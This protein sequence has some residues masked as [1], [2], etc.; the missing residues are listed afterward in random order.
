MSRLRRWGAVGAALAGLAFS[1]VPVAGAQAPSATGAGRSAVDDLGACLA[2]EREGDLLVLIDE[3]SSLQTSDPDGARVRAATYLLEQLA[4]Y[5]VRAGVNL[6]V[7][8]SG[9]AQDY[10]PQVPFTALTESSLPEIR[11]AVDEFQGRTAGGDTDYWAALDGA[12]KTLA[13]RGPGRCQA[14]AWFTDG[15]LDYSTDSGREKPYAPG[16][17]IGSQGDVDRVIASARESICR[18]GGVADQMRSSGVVTLGVGLASGTASESDFGLMKSI[19]TGDPGPDGACGAVQDP[20]PGEFFL[21]QNINDLLFAFDAM[22]TPGQAPIHQEAGVCASAL[23]ED[24][25]HRFVLD[26]SI[27][28]VSILARSDAGGRDV[29]LVLPSGEQVVIKAGS[30]AAPQTADS[31]VGPI[32][33]TWHS[34]ET[35]AIEMSNSAAAPAWTGAWALAF[36]DP[37][38]DARVGRSES[39]IHIAGNLFPAWVGQK[40]DIVHSGEVT[41]DVTLGVVDAERVPVEPNKLLGDVRLSASVIGPD[42]RE[43]VVADGMTKEQLGTPVDLDLTSV[44]PG[45]STM[46]MTLAVT[47]ASA[48]GPGGEQVPGTAL[49]PSVVDMPLNIAAPVGFPVVGQSLDFGTVEGAGTFTAGLP[50]TGPGCVWLPTKSAPGLK[51]LGSPDGVGAVSAGSEQ[52]GTQDS[53]LVLAEGESAELPVTLTTQNEA[54]GTVNGVV[55]VSIAPAGEFDRAIAVDVPFTANV[56]KPLD[57]ANFWLT[58]VMA[59][60]LGPGIPLLL[61]YAAK[62]WTAKIPGRALS[63]ERIAITVSG[64]SVLRDDA[65]FALRDTDLINPVPGL[66]DPVRRLPVAGTELRTHVG[67]SPFGAGFVTAEAAGMIGAS[68]RTPST[69]GK[70]LAARLPLAV[71][72]NWVVLHDPTGPEDRAEVLLLVG[73]DAGQQRRADMVDDINRRLPA[74]LVELR[75]RWV[76]ANPGSGSGGGEPTPQPDPFGG[77]GSGQSFG[78]GVN[79]PGSPGASENPFGSSTGSG[80]DPYAGGTPSGPAPGT[81]PPPSAPD[82]FRF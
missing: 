14:V 7:A 3:S 28:A 74:L 69:H 26:G 34:P 43:T 38:G 40:H 62:W 72:N 68:S 37:T 11:T 8:V 5:G 55:T 22:S 77:V 30:G 16:V 4:G 12:R 60:V 47:T 19:V 54:N 71:H 76:Q 42:G 13:D 2:A 25:K 79:F 17:T 67:A 58:L 64:S 1:T 41:K 52:S 70:Q 75:S 45:Q 6:D 56:Q 18:P 39:N 15:K 61:L 35:V 24:A 66:G 44:P 78:A 9:F 81:P 82:P 51:V 57:A 36:V 65:Q 46:R 29:Y 80:F 31:P 63:A 32:T 73:A 53:C 49:A 59:L 20:R 23:C 21:A 33:Y 50:V 48:K 27:G 10:S